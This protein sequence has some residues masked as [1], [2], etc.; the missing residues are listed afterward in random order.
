M[1]PPPPP[2]AQPLITLPYM[3]AI[4][5][6]L[7]G[8]KL[9]QPGQVCLELVSFLLRLLFLPWANVNFVIL[10]KGKSQRAIKRHQNRHDESNL[11]AT[12][13]QTR[14]DERRADS[15]RLVA[16]IALPCNPAPALVTFVLSLSYERIANLNSSIIDQ[17]RLSPHAAWRIANER[18]IV[19]IDGCVS[20]CSSK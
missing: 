5:R 7:C 13:C 10:C 12:S 18:S 6:Q 15:S 16:A 20:R 2:L 11:M 14:P 4:K 3:V 19:S 1:R 9:R 8:Q 17:T